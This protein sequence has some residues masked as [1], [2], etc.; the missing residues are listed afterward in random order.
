MMTNAM[1]Y[2]A[3]LILSLITAAA[4]FVQGAS[5]MGFAL[6]L[7]PIFGLLRPDFLP[8]TLLILMLPLNV[9]V[10]WNERKA[11]D[12]RGTRWIT[13]GRFWGTFGG[14]WVLSVLSPGQLGV[15]VGWLTIAAALVALLAPPFSPTHASA[16]GA[17]VVT[18]ITE[19]ATGI[20]GP[21]LAL[22]YQHAP[23]AVLRA[24]ITVCFFIGEIISLAIL[25]WMEMVTWID[26]GHALALTPAALIGTRLARLVH[27][28]INGR[29]LRYFVL[30]FALV[31]GTVLIARG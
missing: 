2:D 10:F 6:I 24:T 1:T 16:L 3:F 28:R 23:P 20:G 13:L 30:I 26:W 29:R 14:L 25:G 12:W 4:A 5:G 27:T 22:L 18:G 7:A 19:T 17:G 31:S 8:A 11:I 21:P 15:A 9:T